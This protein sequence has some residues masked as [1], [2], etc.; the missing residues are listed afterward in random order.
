MNEL[1]PTKGGENKMTNNEKLSLAIGKLLDQV[2]ESLDKGEA[3]NAET[4][5]ALQILIQL[6]SLNYH[7]SEQP[8]VEVEK[9]ADELFTLLSSKARDSGITD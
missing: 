4:L 9:F 1:I 7:L 8:I 5:T 3:I 6:T 2:N